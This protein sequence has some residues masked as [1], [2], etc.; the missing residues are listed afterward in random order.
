MGSLK[1]AALA[2]AVVVAT[3]AAQEPQGSEQQAFRFRSGVEL[4]NV[5]ATVHDSRGRFVSGLQQD[6][7]RVYE[8]G[9]QRPITHFTAERVPVS[10]GIV[11]DT[12]SSME[13]EKML[14][15][16]QALQRFLFE[17]LG[18]DDEVFLY[19]FDNQPQ[20]LVRWTADRSGTHGSHRTS[21]QESAAHH[22]RRQ[23]HEQRHERERAETTHSA[24]RGA[25]IRDRDR[26]DP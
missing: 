23:R 26:C 15:A 7:F 12:S 5:S 6:D 8:D 4:I 24:V 3:A 25:R 2:I 21:P 20:L 1:L 18:P 9:Q 14:A 11:V 16:R 19:K 17:L 13:G 22:L 10:L